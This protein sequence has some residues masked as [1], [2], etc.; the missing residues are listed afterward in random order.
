MKKRKASK[1][2]FYSRSTNYTKIAAVLT[3]FKNNFVRFMLNHRV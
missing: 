1:Q 3:S 2:K